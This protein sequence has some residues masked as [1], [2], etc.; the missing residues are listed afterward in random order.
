[1]RILVTG[2]AGFI[3][4]HIVGGL[5]TDGREV[6]VLDNLATGRLSN[7]N[8]VVDDVDFVEGDVRDLE[9]VRRAMRDCD[10]VMHLA[11]VPSVPYRVQA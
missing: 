2:G 6:R 3:G 1:M 8:E 5:L 11:A 7:L 9:T 10:A 4:S